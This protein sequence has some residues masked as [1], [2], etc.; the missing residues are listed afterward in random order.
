M[1]NVWIAVKLNEST[2]LDQ[3]NVTFEVINVQ[4]GCLVLNMQFVA[5]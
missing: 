1:L 3:F 5:S 4:K 2:V